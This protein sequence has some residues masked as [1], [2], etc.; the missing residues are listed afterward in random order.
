MHHPRLARPAAR[1]LGGAAIVAALLA[2]LAFAPPATASPPAPSPV[3][4]AGPAAAQ[5]EPAITVPGVEGDYLRAI[6]SR[7]HERWAKGFVEGLTRAPATAGAAAPAGDKGVRT[8]VLFAVRWDGTVAEV[9]LGTSSGVASFDKAAIDAVR[10]ADRFPVPPV[11]VFSDDGI[12]HVRW[13]LSR[14]QRLCSDGQ[15]VRREDPLEEALPRLFIQSRTKEALLR[16]K[17]RIDARAAGDPMA[18]FA[19]AWLARQNP[20]P[21]ADIEAAAALARLGD[22]RQVDRLRA[23]LAFPATASTAVAALHATR[24][25]VC[26]LVQ[27]NLATGD[28]A[29][30]VLAASILREAGDALPEPGPCAQALAANA[31]DRKQPGHVRAAALQTLGVLSEASAQRLWPVLIKDGDAVVRAAAISASAHPGGG[32]PALYRLIPFLRD[33][34]VD[35]RAATAAAMVRA[36]GDLALDQLPGALKDPD[37]RI[38]VALATALA[39]QQTAAS[40]AM[41]GRLAKRDAQDVRVAAVSALAARTDS[42]ARALVAPILQ[43]AG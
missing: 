40:A 25:D 24:V 36:A 22:T 14:D 16:V 15:L 8:V 17:R 31:G 1:P 20:D 23:G 4:S 34:S 30:R 6:H 35:V 2:G 12:V 7:I 18:L 3:A 37:P 38:G 11:D 42:A 41:L 27:S 26:P 10:T 32:R 43:A 21:M 9:N 33:P 13:T 19:R 28:P 29:A 39:H 5:A